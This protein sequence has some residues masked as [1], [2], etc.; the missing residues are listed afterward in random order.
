L[1]LEII[2]GCAAGRAYIGLHQNGDIIPCVYMTD[3]IVGNVLKDNLDYLWSN[4]QIFNDLRNRD[5]LQ[6][7]CP[8]CENEYICGGCRARAY[9]Y[10]K[11][12]TKPDIGCIN[13]KKYL[14]KYMSS[15]S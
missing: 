13:N 6:G 7:H 9:G 2:G 15:N 8:E 14:E 12:A 1:L 5:G 10:F 3:L 11:D 4:N